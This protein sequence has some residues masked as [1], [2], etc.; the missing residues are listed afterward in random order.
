MW[1]QILEKS[2]MITSTKTVPT[3]S[4]LDLQH[5]SLMN[6]PLNHKT[7]SLSFSSTRSYRLF[8]SHLYRH[9]GQKSTVLAVSV[10]RFQ[11]MLRLQINLVWSIYLQ[12]MGLRICHLGKQIYKLKLTTNL[13][14]GLA[15]MWTAEPDPWQVSLVAPTVALMHS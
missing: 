6:K 3:A 1:S 5:G 12:T 8:L 13:Q 2:R 9:M 14:L 7:L 11:W 10:L 4:L 15:T